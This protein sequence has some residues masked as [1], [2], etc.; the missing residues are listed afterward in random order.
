[1]GIV[2]LDTIVLLAEISFKLI[3]QVF[4]S[5]VFLKLHQAVSMEKN[6]L[7]CSEY[8][9]YGIITWFKNLKRKKICLVSI[10]IHFKLW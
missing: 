6:S 7:A 4:S 1:M 8:E 10:S 9:L 3:F 2:S 5:H